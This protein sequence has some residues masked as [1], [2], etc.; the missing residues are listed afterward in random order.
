MEHEHELPFDYAGAPELAMKLV[1]SVAKE[2]RIRMTNAT[3]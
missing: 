2:R 1:R 3:T